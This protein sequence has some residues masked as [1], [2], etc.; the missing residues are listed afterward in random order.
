MPLVKVHI[1][2]QLGWQGVR[3][4]FESMAN[5]KVKYMHA[6]SIRLWKTECNDE[7]VRSVCAYMKM[8]KD[9]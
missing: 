1:F 8:N 7:G 2:E 3:A 4:I 9:V 5:E 6:R